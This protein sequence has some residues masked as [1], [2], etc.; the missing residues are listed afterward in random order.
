M[1]VLF[2]SNTN[3]LE[4]KGLRNA[5]DLSIINDATLVA[6]IKDK[7]GVPL[8]GENWPITLDYVAGSEGVYQG[9][10][11]DLLEIVLN[12]VYTAEITAT[13]GGDKGFWKVPVRARNRT[14]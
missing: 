13:R 3:L 6:T 11:S 10:A 7:A 1:E 9:L 2:I 4:I 5:A 12:D 8:V 14:S